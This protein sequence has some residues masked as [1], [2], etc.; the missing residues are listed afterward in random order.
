MKDIL[1]AFSFL[2]I[3]PVGRFICA[4]EKALVRAMA[5]YPLVG[6][7][8]GFLVAFVQYLFSFL[9]PKALVLWLVIGLLCLVTRGLH[10]DGFADTIDGLACG[11]TRG[12]GFSR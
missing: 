11:G 8:I 10:M 6:L 7:V 12:R 2:T 5:F 4:D 9:L 3:L 1:L